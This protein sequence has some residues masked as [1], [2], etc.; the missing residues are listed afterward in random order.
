MKIKPIVYKTECRACKTIWHS[1]FGFLN[2]ECKHMAELE[3][4]AKETKWIGETNDQFDK[5]GY[6][7]RF[8]FADAG[9]RIVSVMQGRYG[10]W[11]EIEE[12]KTEEVD[13][14]KI[15]KQLTQANGRRRK[16]IGTL[17]NALEFIDSSWDYVNSKP[18]KYV[19]E[20][21]GVES[22]G[23]RATCYFLVNIDDKIYFSIK[24]GP[25]DNKSVGRTWKALQPWRVE[26]GESMKEKLRNWIEHWGIEI[27]EENYSII[28][29]TLE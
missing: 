2:H 10:E 5:D 23:G 8:N 17:R 14:D 29:K 28:Q 27:S 7:W 20:G 22:C 1:P 26:V 21:V 24:E 25:S 3:I 11:W 6:F 4:H 12:E 9:G 13:I 18:F 15:K 19:F 16:R